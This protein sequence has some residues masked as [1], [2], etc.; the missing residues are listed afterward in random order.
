MTTYQASA[1]FVATMPFSSSPKNDRNK[2]GNLVRI[3][4]ISDQSTVRKGLSGELNDCGFNVDTADEETGDGAARAGEYGAVVID[5]DSADDG[6]LAWVTKW[7]R[8]GM[9]TKVLVLL[10]D[11]IRAEERVRCVKLGADDFLTKPFSNDDLKAR[12]WTLMRKQKKKEPAIERVHDLE[13]DA[14]QWSVRRGGASIQLTQREFDLLQFLILHQG[15][16]V[17]RTMILEHMYHH[18]D[19]ERRSNVV[20]VYVSYLRKKIDNDPANPLIVTHWGKG[21]EFL[22]DGNGQ[23]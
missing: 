7:R 20:D 2:G 14:S 3:L 4:L 19:P 9:K 23:E 5:L 21:Y 10:D 17:T 13:L 18:L 6:K 11:S 8:R 16:I 12:L 22:R 1:P 15:K